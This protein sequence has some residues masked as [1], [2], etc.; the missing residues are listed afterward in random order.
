MQDRRHQNQPR[1][2]TTPV[3]AAA[4]IVAEPKRGK[5][6]GSY[7]C[8]RC[9][10]PKKGHSCYVGITTDTD[11]PNSI[12][13]TH[14]PDLSVAV[15]ATRPPSRHF[16]RALSFDDD[17]SDIHGGFPEPEDEDNLDVGDTVADLGSGRFPAGCLWEILRR[18][19]PAGLLASARVCRGWRETAKRL[20]KA[21]EELRLRVPAR[22][23]VGLVGSVLQK[24]PGIVRLSLRM[25]RLGFSDTGRYQI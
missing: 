11:S 21:A 1:R 3:G 25:E 13:P 20:W 14:A 15:S 19:P 6:R 16:R 8:G 2:L 5:K 22:A 24:C 7:T 17:V 12:T 23:Q 4:I 18:L 10:L 9:G